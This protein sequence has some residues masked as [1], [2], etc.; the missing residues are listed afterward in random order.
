[1][2]DPTSFSYTFSANP[3]PRQTKRTAGL[4]AVDQLSEFPIGGDQVLARNLRNGREMA[5]PADHLN[6]LVGFCSVFRT[7]DE[8]VAEL[9]EGSDGAPERAAAIRGVVQSFQD[10]GLTI[11]AE[12]V[13]RELAPPATASPIT[14]KPVVV[15][16]TCDRPLAL[17]RLLESIRSD[18]ALEAV[19]ELWI[20]DDSRSA[21]NGARN[22]E[23]TAAAGSESSTGFHYFGAVEAVELRDA[24]IGRLPQHEDSIRFLLD[25]DRWREH[26]S[27]GL[28]RNFS[29]LLSVGKPVV[30]FDDD[31][32]C[33]A[34]A[35]ALNREGVTFGAGQREAVF[36]PDDDEWRQGLARLPHDPVS[37]H[38]QC[39]G[40]PLPEA[41]ST[42]G[43]STL[44]QHN[45]QNAQRD[46]VGR[47][48]RDSRILVTESGTL[49]DPG[50]GTN[51]WLATLPIASREALAATEG[52]LQS[53]LRQRCCW[54]GRPNPVFR[55]HGSMSLVTGFD[56]RGF[57][58]PYFPVTRGEDRLFGQ[59][60]R[61]IY[62]DSIVL[63]YPW[64][65]PHLPM[66]ERQWS[67][68]EGLFSIS[69]R[70]PGMLIN[71][72]LLSGDDCLAVD[73]EA[74]LAFL[75]RRV[76]DLAGASDTT[77]LDRFADS[78]HGYRA[79]QLRKLKKVISESA[80][81][82]AEWR[83]YVEDALRQVQ[84]SQLADF[85]LDGLK[86]TEVGLEGSELLRFWR[87]AWR[88]FGQSL[89][90]WNDIREAAREIVAKNHPG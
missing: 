4:F 43:F 22:R 10:G 7:L 73:T 56:N 70:F 23:L 47:L 38:M 11:S 57:L 60:T 13:C 84:A 59:M 41:L 80:D 12:E 44:Q 36:F 6:T 65:V 35:A 28:A 66:P 76:E 1:M 79:S 21:E 77:L 50:T 68:Q 87:D 34:Y 30:V 85:K 64:A 51:R 55:R 81:L 37:G 49:G 5:L 24:L 2:T 25:R 61:Y 42:L 48:K 72:A 58:P 75:A 54:L 3:P 69:G 74:R 17:E 16:I 52:R 62:P 45:L 32:L 46:F 82:P 9:M 40:Q 8:H 31:A 78:T 83:N 90:A 19:D 39:L 88:A 29:H 14:D 33:E 86:S 20:V 63:D 15:I 18:C 89:T 27:Y 71:E 53:A 67:R 26:K